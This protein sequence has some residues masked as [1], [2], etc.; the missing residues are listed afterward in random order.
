MAFTLKYKVKAERLVE[1]VKHLL[2]ISGWHWCWIA[3]FSIFIYIHNDFHCF[4]LFL[5]FPSSVY[6]GVLYT[7]QCNTIAA[8]VSV[9]T[10]DPAGNIWHILKYLKSKK[11]LLLGGKLCFRPSHLSSFLQA[12]FY[13]LALS[14]IHTEWNKWIFQG[15]DLSWYFQ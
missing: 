1:W 13:S 9:A 15:L 5:G 4:Q 3:T 2:H 8:F 14:Y 6:A 10:C 12:G 7:I 11:F